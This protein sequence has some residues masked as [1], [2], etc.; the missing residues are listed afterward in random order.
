[1]PSADFRVELKVKCRMY[2]VFSSADT[3]N[4]NVDSN[5]IAF[6]I[7]DIKFYVPVV[8]LSA[9]DNQELS[10]LLSKGFEGSV[11]WN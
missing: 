8:T 4:I 5:N 10:K 7:K 6:T 11:Y 1:M 2:Y 9:K 3:D